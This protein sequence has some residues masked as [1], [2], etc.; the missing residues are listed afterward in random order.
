MRSKLLPA[1]LSV[2]TLAV[3]ATALADGNLEGG[4]AAGGSGQ[5]LATG[6]NYVGQPG[7]NNNNADST[8]TNKATTNQNNSQTQSAACQLGCNNTGQ[9]QTSDQG[10]APL[11][12]ALSN[13][14]VN[15][16]GTATNVSPTT[17]SAEQGNNDAATSAATNKATTNQTNS[18]TQP[19]AC[20][21]GCNNTGQAQTSD[22]ATATLQAA[23]SNAQV[24][25]TGTTTNVLRIISTATNN[26]T[27]NQNNS[28]TQS[29]ACQLGCNNT[30]QAQTSDQATATLQAAL[31]NAVINQTGTTTNVLWIISTATNNATT[32]QNNS[33]T[34]S[35]ACQR[36]CSNTGQ[37]QTSDQATATLQA[38]LSNA[39]VNQTGT[40]TNV[41]SINAPADSAGDGNAGF[42]AALSSTATQLIW[43]I[44]SAGC[45]AYC[46]GL[47]QT[48]I[49]GQQNT[50]IQVAQGVL[51]SAP[52]TLALGGSPTTN[53]TT[54][55]QLGC[56]AQCSGSTTTSTTAPALIAQAVEQVLASLLPPEVA[57]QR[58]APA[59][60]QS[61]VNQTSYQLQQG[62]GANGAQAQVVTQGG[63]TAQSV[64]LPAALAA[65]LG[66]ALGS[67]GSAPT[68]VSQTSQ[69]IWQVQIGCIIFCSRTQQLQQAQQSSTTIEVVDPASAPVDQTA[70]SL[71]NSVSQVVWQLQVGCVFWCYDATEQ[72]TASSGSVLEVIT[73]TEPAPSSANPT[74][75]PDP[76]PAPN[77][78]S[79][80][81]TAA[82]NPTST[83]TPTAPEPT[84][85]PAN[86]GG[87]TA[88][89]DS[90][91]TFRIPSNG[92]GASSS[93]GTGSSSSTGSSG[94]PTPS[95]PGRGTFVVSTRLSFGIAPVG[96]AP[97]SRHV[98]PNTLIASP[99][100]AMLLAVPSLATSPTAA[101]VATGKTDTQRSAASDAKSRAGLIGIAGL[102]Q[103]GAF[104]L[105]A[106]QRP[107]RNAVAGATSGL[108][109][110]G[111]L[112]AILAVV[113]VA[114]A[115]LATVRAAK[116]H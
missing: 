31:S 1:V 66:P 50:T 30:G 65:S 36:G 18:Q 100:S 60:E 64:D 80:P 38:A 11:E 40:T 7:N 75:P 69:R 48:Q 53:S 89:A 105:L 59:S 106:S 28:Q 82:P 21:L 96:K 97:G 93:G 58:P 54:Q 88:P 68:A 26:A 20:Q 4:V 49:A 111:P 24:N 86:A 78:T 16:T 115:G 92:P 14:Q 108:G 81:P 76:T 99:G 109:L 84:A 17:T 9:A 110:S 112:I 2:L 74:T 73:G 34:Q 35:A 19:A 103:L 71:V 79:T 12:A 52:G 55:I 114:A 37:A 23:L 6:T 61:T 44:Q 15:Q 45:L 101:L 25:Q 116:H 63:L 27:T 8:A 107:A 102:P 22:Q 72:Q 94:K 29:A 104:P 91:P 77:A 98:A 95:R 90:A 3:P 43:Q 5:E 85:A 42:G 67:T 39:Q 47:T 83:P 32:N 51:Q 87:Q 70:A 57:G 10:A 13:A 62:Q 56:V 113:A 46:Q 33:Q 41:A